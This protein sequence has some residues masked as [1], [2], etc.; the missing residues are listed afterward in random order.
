MRADGVVALLLGAY[1]LGVLYNGNSEK[2][3][4]E[5][6][7]DK[8]FLPWIGA[9]IVVWALVEGTKGTQV[10]PLVQALAVAITVAD[11]LRTP[12]EVF[13][14]FRKLIRGE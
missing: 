6:K 5:L 13:D 8:A 3:V 9:I 10:G 2:L 1:L 7:K 14:N 4:E 12:Q 11:L